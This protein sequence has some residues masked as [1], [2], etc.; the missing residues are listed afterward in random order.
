VVVPVMMMTMMAMMAGGRFRLCL[1]RQ[2]RE[3][4]GGEE[5][6]YNG[7]AHFRFSSLLDESTPRA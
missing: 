6:G 4:H 5:E 7:F 2:Q 3:G 1:N